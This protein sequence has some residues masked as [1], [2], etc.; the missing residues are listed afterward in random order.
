MSVHIAISEMRKL[1]L[2]D[3]IYLLTDSEWCSHIKTQ[4]PD[5]RAHDF[6][7]LHRVG[8]SCVESTFLPMS[9]NWLHKSALLIAEP[10]FYPEP[11]SVGEDGYFPGATGCPGNLSAKPDSKCRNSISA[12]IRGMD[13]FEM[14]HVEI[15]CISSCFLN[16]DHF[17]KLG[18]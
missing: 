8:S 16:Y 6:P 14:N 17:Y 18:T 5:S 11:Q 9:S 4:Q 2:K 13:P 1:R 7:F 10:S 15:N 12:L 3:V